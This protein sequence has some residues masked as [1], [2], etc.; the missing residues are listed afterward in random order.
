[1]GVRSPMHDAG[2]G[3]NRRLVSIWDTLMLTGTADSQRPGG[4]L[5]WIYAKRRE[6]TMMHDVGTHDNCQLHCFLGVEILPHLFEYSIGNKRLPLHRIDIRQ[7][8]P[9]PFVKQI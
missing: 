7:P 4:C 6:Y 9:L 5:L 8:C 1:M 3:P 2:S